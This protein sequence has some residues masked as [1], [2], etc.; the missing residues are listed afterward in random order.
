MH[1]KCIFNEKEQ[2]TGELCGLVVLQPYGYV[3]A[4]SHMKI[5]IQVTVPH[6]AEVK[7]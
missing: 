6:G 1:T 4:E 3:Y 7:K 2:W 5:H